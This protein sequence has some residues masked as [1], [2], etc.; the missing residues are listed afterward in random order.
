MGGRPGAQVCVSVHARVCEGW[1]G[2]QQV[3]LGKVIGRP[4][5]VCGW[6]L[7]VRVLVDSHTT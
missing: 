2:D 6:V 5:G 3:H 1:W 4:M 7:V